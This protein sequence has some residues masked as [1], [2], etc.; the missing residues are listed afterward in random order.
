M[1]DIHP[2]LNYFGKERKMVPKSGNAGTKKKAKV[3]VGKLK[4]NKE[5]V[6]DLTEGERKKVKGGARAHPSFNTDCVGAT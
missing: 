1:C 4:V 6:K 5:T 3:K 2:A